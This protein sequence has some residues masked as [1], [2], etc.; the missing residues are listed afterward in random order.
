MYKLDP[1]KKRSFQISNDAFFYIRDGEEPLDELN[2]EEAL[3]VLE[4]FPYGFELGED[5]EYIEGTDLVQVNFTPYKNGPDGFYRL[6]RVWYFQYEWLVPYEVVKIWFYNTETEEVCKQ[7][8]LEVLYSDTGEPY[9]MTSD[10]CRFYLK[11]NI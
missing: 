2:K 6:S 3:E 11:D 7:E 1:S 5:W 10:L 4:M 9:V 8:E